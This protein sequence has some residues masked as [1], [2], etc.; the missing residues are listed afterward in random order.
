MKLHCYNM[1]EI[2]S[3]GYCT[4][5]TLAYNTSS[6]NHYFNGNKSKYKQ[7][8]RVHTGWHKKTGTFEMRSGS[9]VQLAALRNRDLDLQTTSPFSN[10]GSVERPSCNGSI[11][12]NKIFLLDFYNFCWVFQKIPF[13]CVTLYKQYLNIVHNTCIEQGRTYCIF[14]NYKNESST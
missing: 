9:H 12:V 8:I 4:L 14:Y 2:K 7:S 1:F 11:S 10:H 6:I 13:C 5:V 3:L